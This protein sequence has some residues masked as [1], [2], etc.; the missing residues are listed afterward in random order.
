MSKITKI[1]PLNDGM[2]EREADVLWDKIAA[3]AGYG[4][5]RS[6]A[7]EYSL[8]SYQSCWLK[9]HYPV[10]FFA[11]ALSLMD[12]DKLPALLRDAKRL[13]I[14]VDLP[15]VNLS[16]N[17]FEII[18]DT[19]L[20]IPFSRVK[21]L[22]E[23]TSNAILEARKAGKFKSI[24]DF[25]DRVNKTIVN[26]GKRAALDKIGAF[27]SIEP[28]QLAARHPDRIRDQRELIPGLIEANVPV[29]RTMEIDK[30]DKARLGK[31]V[32]EYRDKHADDGMPVKPALGKHA[33]FMVIFDAPSWSEEREGRMAW[34]DSFGAVTEALYQTGF[35]INDGYWTALIKRPKA[36]KQVSPDEISTYS[37]YLKQE[38]ETLKP[39][40]IVMMG[41]A[42]VRHFIPDFKGKASDSAGKVIYNADLDANLVIGFSPG[43]VWH[44]KSKQIAMNEV[45]GVVA[46]LTEV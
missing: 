2:E 16:T 39:P 25:E 37:V 6:H 41:S 15:D 44:D 8:I 33:K 17:T 14:D 11:A 46:S 31:I 22:T 4:F 42:T 5:N 23:R 43:E 7:V 19:R 24:K 40:V 12:E 28:G 27:A 18:T 1:E 10:E 45:F 29:N 34:G 3:F 30:F 38:I 35:K 32:E 20:C 21:G 9:T 13:G 26:S 36:G